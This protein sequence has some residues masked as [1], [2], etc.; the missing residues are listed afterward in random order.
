M[1]YLRDLGINAIEIMPVAEFPMS[2][3]WG[4]NPSQPFSVE[5]ALGGPRGLHEFV[6]AAHAHGIAVILD[7][8]YNHFGPGDLDL[9]RFDGWSRCDHDGGIYF[10]DNARAHTPWGDTRPDYGRP[11]VRQYIRDNALFWL[12]QVSV[13]RVAVRFRDQHPQSQREQQRPGQRHARWLEPAAVDQRRDPRDAAVEDHD[14][15]GFAEQRMDHQA[16]R[17]LA[18]LASAR[19]GTRDSSIRSATRSSPPTTPIA[20]CIS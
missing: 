14:R 1:P 3:S 11:E 17:A 4:Y 5:S 10:Y 13:G 18:A 6:K 16:T 7:V 12:E 9:W 15:R 20:T 19:N 2:I 8:V